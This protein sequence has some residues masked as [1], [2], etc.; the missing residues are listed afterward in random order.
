MYW[1]TRDKKWVCELSVNKK[2][3]RIGYF[4]DF[5]LAELV[6]SEARALYHGPYA[7]KGTYQ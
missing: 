5:D 6:I 4:D 1:S 2:I 3:R 7:S